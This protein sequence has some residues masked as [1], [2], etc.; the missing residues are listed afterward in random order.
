MKKMTLLLA[1]VFTLAFQAVSQTPPRGIKYQAVARNLKG[2]VLANEKITLRISLLSLEAG[3]QEVHYSEVH[4]MVTNAVGLFSLTIG[5]GQSSG[6]ELDRVPWSTRN[7][8][9]EVAIREKSTGVFAVISNSELLAVPYAFHAVTAS[10]LAEGGP[11]MENNGPGVPANVWS[12]KG[13]SNT[14]PLVDKLGTTDNKDLILVTNNIERF[15]ITAAGDINIANSLRVGID[16]EVGNDL[17]VKKNVF[18]NTVSGSTTNNG[19]FT[20]ANGNPTALTG[21]L[22][23]DNN[24]WLKSRLR[25]DGITDLNAALNVNNGAATVLTG[26]LR[27][28]LAA[29]FKNQVLIDNP[30]L[31][32][33]STTTGGLVVAGGA[34]IGQNLHVGGIMDVTGNALFRGRAG[35]G[36]IYGNTRFAISAPAA[37]AFPLYVEVSGTPNRFSVNNNG[38]VY[39]RSNKSGNSGNTGNYSMFVDGQ[40]QGIVVR[41]N[42]KDFPNNENNYMSFWGAN[43]VVRGRIEGQDRSDLYSSFDY[44]WQSAMGLADEAFVIAEGVATGLQADAAEVV[45]MAVEGLVVYAKWAEFTINADNNVGIAYESGSG[46]YAEWLMKRN[47]GETFTFGDIVSVSA[48]QISKNTGQPG[49]LMVVSLSPIVLGN[50]PE[51]GREHLYEKVA[52]MGQV[53][54]KVIGAVR[55]GDYIIPSGRNDGFG[56]AV[57][58]EK[59]TLDQYR[60]IVGVAW[61]ETQFSRGV[62]FVN[63]AVGINQQD[64]VGQLQKQQADITA[65]KK[66]WQSL[67]TYLREKDPAFPGHLLDGEVSEEVK[68]TTAM[69]DTRPSIAPVS[70]P[71]NRNDVQRQY[72]ERLIREKPELLTEGLRR[73]REKFEQKGID[74]SKYPELQKVFTDRSFLE[75]KLREIYR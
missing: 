45:V 24:T 5:N 46:D 38:Q 31:G 54:V 21:Q 47:P 6:Q 23:V 10:R 26:T 4:E 50:M 17:Y 64:L 28:D 49:Q 15:K 29:T 61:S 18:L 27:A 70:L 74:I 43:N 62:S 66:Q 16:V 13:N 1:T 37:D 35:V 9:M 72:V 8:W 63:V 57:S 11:G 25:T 73:V 33:T 48:G 3:R 22:T 44:I 68:N 59:M 65:M 75:Q 7:I 53:P 51:K 34:G 58:P 67:V 55:P 71:T 60:Q 56:I 20:V 2:E 42:G 19:S 30:A 36:T 12:L 69:A 14:N 52:F 39:L 32:S 40:D 41:L